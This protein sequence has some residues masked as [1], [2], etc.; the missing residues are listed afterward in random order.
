MKRCVCVAFDVVC[1]GRT[2]FKMKRYG[3]R[4]AWCVIYAPCVPN[5]VLHVCCVWRGVT[6]LQ[7]VP[8]EVLCVLRLAWCV[9]DIPCVRNEVL[10]VL[11]LA[12][13]VIDAQR[14]QNEAL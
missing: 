1:D 7:C 2:L 13:C 11:R 4:L 10:Y 8:N 5:E 9:T 3:D 6:D 14:V 12:W